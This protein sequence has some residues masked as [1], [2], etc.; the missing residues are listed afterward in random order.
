V[1]DVGV[2]AGAASV[3]L[4]PA[5]IVGVDP[6]A[7]LLAA[8]EERAVAAGIEPIARRGVWPDVAEAAPTVDVVVCHHVVYNVRDLAGFATAM[9]EHASRRVVVELTAVHPM[10]WLAP[11]W[12][13]L[14]GIVQPHRPTAE[15]VEAVLRGLG[16]AV[17]ARRWQRDLQMIGET[18]GDAVAA[19]ARRLCLPRA[20]RPELIDL[21]ARV[22]PPRVRHV[23]TLFWDR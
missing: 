6:S 18:G 10:A 1:L 20:R 9:T 3:R 21:L 12:E 13:A 19:I 5:R 11:Y 22:P 7:E 16:L 8:F 23:V 2:G 17:H 4:R 15:D 14:H